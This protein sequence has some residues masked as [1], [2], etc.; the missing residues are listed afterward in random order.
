MRKIISALV[1]ISA[2]VAG[3][4]V[5]PVCAQQQTSRSIVTGR[6]TDTTGAV[7][8]GA[9]IQLQPTGVKAASDVQGEFA[10]PDLSA[11]DYKLTV[12]FLGFKEFSADLKLAAGENKSFDARLEVANDAQNVLVTADLP[13]GEAEAINRTRMADNIMQ[14]LPSQIITSLPNANVADAVG[15]MPSVSLERIEG[16]GVY[17]QVRGTEPR[18]TNVTIDGIS[19]PSPEPTVRQIRLDVIPADLIESVEL[20]KTLMPNIDGDGIGGSV[21]LRTKL[22]GEFPTLSLY[23]IGG[24]DSILSGRDS[25]QYGGTT[26]YRFGKKKQFGVL[27]GGSKDYNGRGI[28]NEQPALD[29]LSTFAKPIYD[30]NTIREYRYYRSRWGFTGN[31]DYKINDST[32]IYFKSIYSNLKDYGDKWYYEPV[33]N[34]APKFYTSSKRPDAS[35]ASYLFGN[36]KQFTS[37]LLTWDVSAARSYELDSAGNPKADFSWIGPTLVC[38]YDPTTQTSTTVPHFGSGC[39]GP[40]SPLQVAANWGF[41]DITTSKG[42]SAQ[43]NLGGSVSYSQNYHAGKHFGIFESGFKIRNAHK[44]QD[45]SENVYDGWKAASYPMT[46]FL[47]SFSSNN[48]FGGNYFGGHFGPVSDFNQLQTFTLANLSSFLDG[49]KTASAT[50]SGQYNTIERITAGYM[51]NTM[52]FGRWHIVAGVRFEGTQMNARG[53]NVILYPAGSKNCLLATGCGTATPSIVA[54]TYVTALPSLSA[55]YRLTQ[56]SGLRFVYGYGISRPDVYQLT[57]YVSEDDSTNP[58]TVAI[59]NPNLKPEHAHNFDAL[60]EKYLNPLGIIQAGFFYKQITDTLISTSYTGAANGAYAGDLV[61]Q[62]INAGT[63]H[64]YGFEAAYQ[65]RLTWLPRPFGALGLLANFGWSGS[66]LYGIPGRTDHPTLQ[67]QAPINWNISPTY[68]KGR[69]SIRVG[70]AYNGAS[71]YSYDYQLASDPSGLG[72]KGPSGDVYTLAHLQL[73]V[74]GSLRLKYGFTFVASGLNLTNE[75]FGY[76][77]GSPIFVNQ[78]EYYQPTYSVGLRYTL[79]REK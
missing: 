79:N 39:D 76:Y 29:P 54:P 10:I 62:W 18:Q 52:E 44:Y 19:I 75:V 67:R 72:P 40:N 8:Q 63:G 20:N 12:S 33:S 37:S 28:D 1:M 45:A 74:Q 27:F 53:N 71:I 61:S 24:Y 26:G 6:I 4:G 34:A 25:Y 58:A 60:Y 30:N 32:S 11:G 78:R 51:M 5:V 14:V 73:D 47:S 59:G 13:R 56:D 21:N 50:L 23:G 46:M 7:L 68:D 66:E 77:T 57:P 15:R 35:I 41:K 70:L 31:F 36:R 49:Y 16:E 64:L 48:F 22:A 9:Q 43:L 2:A 55:R 38:G 69:V 3:A 42:L 17:I 65:Q